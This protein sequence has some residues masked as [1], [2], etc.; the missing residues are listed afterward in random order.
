MS[1]VFLASSGLLCLYFGYRFYSKF[2]AQ[3][4]YQLDPDFETPAHA[5]RDD[6]DYVPTN[7]VVLWGHHFTAV[8][9][10]APIIGPAIAVIWGWLPAFLWVVIGLDGA[11]AVDVIQRHH[12]VERGSVDV[13]VDLQAGDVPNIDVVPIPE[14]LV[15]VPRGNAIHLERT[16]AQASSGSSER[17]I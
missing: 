3:R 2:V 1:G 16:K 14:E 11:E 4:I 13:P 6:V 9:G 12:H 17:N 5:M 8:A 15:E 10:A 7:R